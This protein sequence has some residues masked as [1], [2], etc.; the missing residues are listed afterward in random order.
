LFD[1]FDGLIAQE[2]PEIFD[3]ESVLSEA[4]HFVD[5][6]WLLRMLADDHFR[7]AF[8]LTV[9]LDGVNRFILKYG[10]QGAIWLMPA[11]PA[12]PSFSPAQK[13]IPLTANTSNSCVA[14]EMSHYPWRCS[15]AENPSAW[16]DAGV[17]RIGFSD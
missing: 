11:S 6:V 13:F 7:V 14:L 5:N 1:R 4:A 15:P 8:N 3:P 10:D 17:P 9:Q 12:C 16:S 2:L